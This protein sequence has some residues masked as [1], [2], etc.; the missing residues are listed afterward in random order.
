MRVEGLPAVAEPSSWTKS[1]VEDGS[2]PGTVGTARE[3]RHRTTKR[4]LSRSGRRGVMTSSSP[5]RA[6]ARRA[7][8]DRDGADERPAKSRLKRESACVARARSVTVPSIGCAGALV[9]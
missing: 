7:A 5:S 8:V 3:V 9:A 1:A 4:R 6:P 2:S